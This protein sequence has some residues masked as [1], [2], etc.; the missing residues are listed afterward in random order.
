MRL[1]RLPNG[2][3]VVDSGPRATG[4]G[5]YVCPD[6]ECLQRGLSRGRLGHAFR[7][8]SEAGTNLAAE[9]LAAGQREPDAP[10][11]EASAEEAVLYEVGV[12]AIGNVDTMTVRT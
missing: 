4:R 9:A 6:P 1:A 3:V 5:A 12:R 2:M 11:G 10:L 8:P 7:R